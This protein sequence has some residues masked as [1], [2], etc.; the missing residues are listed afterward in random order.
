V[1]TK[2]N[3]AAVL[4]S[5]DR[6]PRLTAAPLTQSCEGEAL[7]FLDE[8]PFHTF[9]L[10]GLMLTN[11][12]ASP[13]LRGKFYVCRGRQGALEGVALIGHANLFETR[14]TPALR[15]FAGLTRQCPGAAF[16]LGEQDE[17]SN[18][19]V[20]YQEHGPADSVSYR[21]ALLELRRPAEPTGPVPDLRPATLDDLDVVVLAHAQIGLR[22]RGVNPLDVDA[23]GFR[24]R[25]ARRI[26]LGRTWVLK[27]EDKHIFKAEIV[28]STPKVTYIESIAVH[29]EEQGKGH[30]LRC[31]SELAR[32]LLNDT[33]S[34]CVLVQERN[35]RALDF[36]RK[37]GFTRVANYTSLFLDRRWVQ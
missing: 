17:V 16:V 1:I 28:C 27:V 24:Q 30:G 4:T 9:G 34:V 31:L 11:G 7:R 6:E 18:F 29:P 5:A 23:A 25:C 26:E 12:V 20:H 35:Q 32:R 19:W 37:V 2:A 13:D 3:T 15:A 21:E 33:D 8:R 10:S 36:Y 14:T 22:E